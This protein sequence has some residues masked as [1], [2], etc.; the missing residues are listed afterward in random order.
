MSL[1]IKKGYV[2]YTRGAS[3]SSEYWRQIH[4][5][6]ISGAGGISSLYEGEVL[7]KFTSAGSSLISLAASE[8]SKEIALLQSAGFNISSIEDVKIFIEHFNEILAGK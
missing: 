5:Q 7:D 8:R 4:Y 2:V 1:S 3:S 6:A